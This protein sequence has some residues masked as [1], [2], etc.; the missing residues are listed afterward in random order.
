M[1]RASSLL[2]A[3]AL[4]MFLLAGC[5]GDPTT[6][7]GDATLTDPENSVTEPIGPDDGWL[8]FGG[9]MTTIERTFEGAFQPQEA[10]TPAHPLITSS[11][12]G[13][14]VPASN[15]L[16]D[17]STDIPADIPVWMN[18]ELTI[19]SAGGGVWFNGPTPAFWVM[20]TDGTAN[21]MTVDAL[22]VRQAE[23][24]ILVGVWYGGPEPAA[25]VAYSVDVTIHYEPSWFASSIPYGF[26]VGPDEVLELRFEAPTEP[27]SI[28]I[29]D[30]DDTFLGGISPEED[31][32]TRL[33]VAPS[34]EQWNLTAGEL[35]IFIT[36]ENPRFQARVIG[37][38]GTLD[39][40]FRV[41]EQI[42]AF[43][44]PWSVE[45]GGE[46][47]IT[48][49]VP[50]QPFQVG[51]TY[52]SPTIAAEPIVTFSGPSGE[53]IHSADHTGEAASG[54]G[55]FYNTDMG[56]PMMPAGPYTIEYQD[57]GSRDMVL[58]GWYVTYGR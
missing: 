24:E 1:R 12:A 6:N 23:E 5:V 33:I 32:D 3:F 25:E 27:E 42:I 41:L 28:W 29:W 58:D 40:D 17:I 20:D 50:V 4:P 46:T 44:G 45:G 52:W 48:Y 7:E 56:S 55:G 8:E 18:A 34:D 15:E 9:E 49:D 38:D 43:Q 19:E 35:V 54:I 2:M 30:G 26:E 47:R 37:P 11:G 21:G 51:Y 31:D 36:E 14:Q 39:T 16:H 13:G 53:Q 10:W 57:T 22:L